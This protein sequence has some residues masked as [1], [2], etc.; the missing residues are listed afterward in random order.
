MPLTGTYRGVDDSTKLTVGIIRDVD[1]LIWLLDPSETPLLTG[2]VDVVTGWLTN[3]TA[4]AIF[5]LL[6]GAIVVA[7]V[8]AVHKARAPEG[9]HH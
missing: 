1:P 3:T 5:G 6:L 4:S 2:Q 9:A 7:I 8:T